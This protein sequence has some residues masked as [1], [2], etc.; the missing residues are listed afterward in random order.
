MLIY[1][2]LI[3]EILHVKPPAAFDVVYVFQRCYKGCS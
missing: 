1:F 3:T 2:H